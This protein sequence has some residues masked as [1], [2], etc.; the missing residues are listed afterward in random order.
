MKKTVKQK[1][2]VGLA[3]IASVLGLTKVN[4]TIDER[5]FWDELRNNRLYV[6]SFNKGEY[7]KLTNLFVSTVENGKFN[8]MDLWSKKIYWLIL[9]KERP[10]KGWTLHDVNRNN[11]VSKLNEALKKRL[12]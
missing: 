2:A 5:K 10:K 9:N 3:T 1:I 7:V 6:T 12:K 4:Q 11:I 8:E